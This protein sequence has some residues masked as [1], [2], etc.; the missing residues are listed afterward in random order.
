MRKNGLSWRALPELSALAL[1]LAGCASAAPVQ[2][3]SQPD[4]S[5]TAAAEPAITPSS[6]AEPAPEVQK[7]SDDIMILYT[8]DIHCGLTQGFGM[9]GLKQIRTTIENNG[10]STLLLDDGDAIQGEVIGTISK[11]EDVIEVMN[12]M[13]YDAAIPGNH[14]FDFGADWFLELA[15]KANYPYICCNLFRKGEQ[16]FPSYLIKEVNGR[17]IGLVGAVTPRTL[18]SCSPENFKDESGEIIYDFCLDSTGERLFQAIQKAV[19]E[20]R[21]EGAE[22]VILMSHIGEE[23]ELAPFNFQT[24]IENTTGIDIIT[25]GH[26]HDTAQVT[27]NNKEGKPVVR[28]ACGTKM[29]AIGYVKLAKDGTAAS[30]LYTWKNEVSVPA[31]LGITNEI[32]PGL[33]KVNAELEETMGR[34]VAKTEVDLVVNDPNKYNDDGTPVKIIR[35]RETNLGDLC[36]DAV[37]AG[38]KTDIALINAGGIRDQ[39]RAGDITY[40]DIISVMPFS[41][42]VCISNLTGQQIIDALEWG[43]AKVPANTGAFLQVSGL[44]YEAHIYIPS[45]FTVDTEGHSAEVTGEYRVKNVKVGGEPIDPKKTYSVSGLDFVLK[46]HGSGFGMM[47]PEDVAIDEAG[48]DN[49][50]LIDYINEDLHGVVGDGYRDPY[51][52][53]R[54]TMIMEKPE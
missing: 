17:K 50:F 30:G 6:S 24:V 5:L 34:V 40:G 54:I 36:A 18:T 48:V 35:G 21:A 51:G 25:D 20:A 16:V 10:I 37:R 41:N 31:L 45:S 33:E 53:G 22:T 44:S 29:Q 47:G 13:N 4:A 12:Q 38:T 7:K 19:D 39:I 1:I 32:T 52:E 11:G 46:H 43:V 2:E 28:T 14:E 8:S 26:S 3:T 49:Q 15:K 23:E 27:M 42:Q 9:E